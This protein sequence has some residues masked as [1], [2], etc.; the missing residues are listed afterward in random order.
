M[1]GLIDTLNAFTVTIKNLGRAK[2]TEPLPWKA[3]RSHPP[4]FRANFGLVDNEH[5]EPACIACQACVRICPSEIISLKMERRVSEVTGKKR[6][7]ATEFTLD[8]NACIFCELCVQVCPSDAIV[9]LN[10]Y[11]LAGYQREDQLL[12]LDKLQENGRSGRTSWATGSRLRAMQDPKRT[13]TPEE[14]R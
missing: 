1:K 2:V 10:S 13:S 11:Q 3:E 9:M 7:Y 8:M 4:R 5:G 14:E 12:N 6:G